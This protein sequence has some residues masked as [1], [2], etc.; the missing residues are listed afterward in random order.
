MIRFPVRIGRVQ[1]G[2]IKSVISTNG[3]IEPVMNFEAHAP[4]LNHR[5]AVCW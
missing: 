5:A 1:K 4:I 2:N 3:K